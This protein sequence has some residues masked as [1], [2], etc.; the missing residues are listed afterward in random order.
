MRCSTLLNLSLLQ[1]AVLHALELVVAH[2]LQEVAHVHRQFPCHRRHVCP[3]SRRL[4][5]IIAVILGVHEH[6]EAA[7]GVLEEYGE[8]AAVGVAGGAKG[9]VRLRACRVL[10][11]GDAHP[12]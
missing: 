4:P 5:R 10:V 12:L 3:R 2:E 1:H 11:A 9:D 8:E 6:L 7:D